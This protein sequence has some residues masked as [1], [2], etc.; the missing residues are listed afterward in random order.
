MEPDGSRD[1]KESQITGEGVQ[2]PVDHVAFRGN[3]EDL[4]S[5]RGPAREECLEEGQWVEGAEH[6]RRASLGRQ[7]C[8]GRTSLVGGRQKDLDNSSGEL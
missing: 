4:E 6:G 5:H 8:S 2:P 1:T 7:L 3:G